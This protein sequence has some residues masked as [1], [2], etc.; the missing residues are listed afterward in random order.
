[1]LD[2]LVNEEQIA[3]YFVLKTPAIE[4]L[5]SILESDSSENRCL[6]A[7]I[8]THLCDSRSPDED[9][10]RQHPLMVIALTADTAYPRVFKALCSTDLKTAGAVANL[11][12]DLLQPEEGSED[13]S[14]EQDSGKPPPACP[15]KDKLIDANLVQ[16]ALTLI[17]HP[18]S[19]VGGMH[20]IAQCC[21]GYQRGFDIVKSI[22]EPLVANA[23]A[24]FFAAFFLDHGGS[25][26][27]RQRFRVADALAAAGALEKASRILT[28]PLPDKEARLQALLGYRLVLTANTVTGEV[29]RENLALP[30]VFAAIIA[31][32][33]VPSM[34]QVAWTFRMIE[35]ENDTTWL[36]N[37]KEFGAIETANHL[38]N[39]LQSVVYDPDP[40]EK[41]APDMNA[42]PDDQFTREY[43]EY[44]KR[45]ESAKEECERYVLFIG[46][47][48]ILITFSIGSLMESLHLSRSLC[49]ASGRIFPRCLVQPSLAPEM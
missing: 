39:I 31:D 45:K 44:T 6:A 4:K 36:D 25:Y 27:T 1:M 28:S 17:Q 29:A 37:W 18:D 13:W 22:L 5:L 46:Y 7:S 33:Y 38:A 10:I 12:G 8:L 48:F 49:P 32:E 26:K 21:W 19:A 23:D 43:K 30:K 35:D 15:T 3:G 9:S 41:D 16:V 34:R 40:E 2:K 14:Y 20:L 24:A 42:L 11:L 47:K